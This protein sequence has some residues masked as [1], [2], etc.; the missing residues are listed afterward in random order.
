MVFPSLL[1]ALFDEWCDRNGSVGKKIPV[2]SVN[3]I[4]LIKFVVVCCS[5]V[6]TILMLHPP[7]NQRRPLWECSPAT[8]HLTFKA[9]PKSNHPLEM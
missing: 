8:C 3:G 4:S 9:Y 6:M 5:G 1:T 7:L 2:S